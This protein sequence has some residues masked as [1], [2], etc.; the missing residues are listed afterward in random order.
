MND[1]IEKLNSEP[2]LML[3]SAIGVVLILFVVL[4]VVIANMRIRTYKNRF[5]NTRVDNE[6]KAKHISELQQEMQ[7]LKSMNERKSSEL[8]QFDTVKLRLQETEL[9]LKEIQSAFGKLEKLQGQTQTKLDNSE[10]MYA[11]LKEEYKVIQQ[12]LEALA[13]ENQKLKVN[14]ARLLMKLEKEEQFASQL[15]ERSF[16]KKEDL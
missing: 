2:L 1:I 4:T 15:Q 7:M 6:A 8:E 13:E 10:Q 9:A 5:I 14:N 3:G 11:A 12:R 16:G